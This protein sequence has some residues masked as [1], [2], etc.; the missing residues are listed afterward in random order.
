M[1]NELSTL[2]LFQGVQQGSQLGCR[3]LPMS[4]LTLKVPLE[5]LTDCIA[6][7]E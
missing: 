2:S 4:A 5:L 7:F 6:P 3:G 1:M